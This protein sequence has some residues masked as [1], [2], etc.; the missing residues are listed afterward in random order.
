[1]RTEVGHF[2]IQRRALMPT[3]PALTVS[4]QI[5]L[6]QKRGLIMHNV[7]AVESFLLQNN[8]YRLNIY[9]HKLMR[10]AEC[11][12]AGTQIDDIL[13]IYYFDRWLRNRLLLLL[14]PIEIHIKT[15]IAYYLG[16]TYGA[17]C[18]YH[19]D[20]FK[21][22]AVYRKVVTDFDKERERNFQDPVIVHHEASYQGVFPIWVIVEF[23]SFNSISNLFFCL[24]ERDKKA[25]AKQAYNINEH[26]L[27]QWLHAL[28]V[29][30]NI[31]AHYGYLY[32]REYS[33]R[34]KLFHEF[35][36][37]VNQNDTLFALCLVLQRLSQK[38]D[39]I[40]FCQS[41]DTRTNTSQSFS[42]SDYGFPVNWLEYLAS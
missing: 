38:N 17:D 27:G 30:R 12:R 11:F 41:L 23:L 39:W 32:Q 28:S 37:N 36:W 13:E 9:F 14:E 26:F 15:R 24:Y 29:L 20:H 31:C 7:A 33:V 18:L 34:P 1:M 2:F 21:N 35:G 40:I 5:Q 4:E 42:L 10:G 22:E 6:L 19:K 16:T 25:I 8:Y 3:K